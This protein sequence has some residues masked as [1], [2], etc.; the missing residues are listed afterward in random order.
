ME[1]VCV[2]YVSGH[3]W[4]GGGWRGFKIQCGALSKG[5][6]GALKKDKD[7]RGGGLAKMQNGE[8]SSTPPLGINNDRSLSNLRTRT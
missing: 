3:Y 8:I 4:G 2:L 7:M 6:G 1:S 5:G